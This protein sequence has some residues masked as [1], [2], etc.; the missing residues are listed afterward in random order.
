VSELANLVVVVV[1]LVRAWYQ[2]GYD[3]QSSNSKVVPGG[4]INVSKSSL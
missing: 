2:L 3:R 1:V 4:T